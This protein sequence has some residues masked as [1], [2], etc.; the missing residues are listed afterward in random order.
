MNTP[1]PRAQGPPLSLSLSF[2]IGRAVQRLE[3]MGALFKF[4]CCIDEVRC[5]G[6][7]T[8]LPGNFFKDMFW[9]LRT[10]KLP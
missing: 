1:G 7:C 4:V 2:F 5:Q 6:T 9:D 10:F 8:E 3:S